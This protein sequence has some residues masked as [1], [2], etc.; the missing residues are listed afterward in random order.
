MLESKFLNLDI[1]LNKNQYLIHSYKFFINVYAHVE[2]NRSLFV[3]TDLINERYSSSD[4]D[5]ILT[6][7]FQEM[8]P[9]RY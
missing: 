2:E 4:K 6:T 1:L 5:Q 3:F 8:T 7:N 9:L